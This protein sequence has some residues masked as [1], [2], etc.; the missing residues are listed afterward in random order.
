MAP[1]HKEARYRKRYG[2]A[3]EDYRRRVPYFIPRLT[4]LTSKGSL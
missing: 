4:T 2:K 1:L 3:F